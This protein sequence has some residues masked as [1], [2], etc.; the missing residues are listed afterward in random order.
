[1]TL[2]STGGRG[3]PNFEILDAKIASALKKIILIYFFKKKASLQ[4]Q[5]RYMEHRF[6]VEDRLRI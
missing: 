4:E 1:M 3:F 6:Y 5:K 2:Q